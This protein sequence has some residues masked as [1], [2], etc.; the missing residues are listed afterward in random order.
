MLT[1]T[2]CPDDILKLISKRI[3]ECDFKIE[4]TKQNLQTK[5]KLEDSIRIYKPLLRL[6]EQG[7]VDFKSL[8]KDSQSYLSERRAEANLAVQNALYAANNVV[9]DGIAGIKV[10][11]NGNDVWLETPDG[12]LVSSS[13][14]G[15]YRSTI[16]VLMRIALLKSNPNNLQFI[17][18]DEALAKLSTENSTIMSSYL[19]VL[20][21]DSQIISIEQKDE[22]FADSSFVSYEFFLDE[23]GTRLEKR[24]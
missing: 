17:L 12:R 18:L 24:R 14:G 15:G 23:N 19:P 1:N 3:N 7:I 4:Q 22:I 11:T 16:G 21:Q 20:A 6:V 13:E 8:V 2:E 10:K 9:S 5:Q